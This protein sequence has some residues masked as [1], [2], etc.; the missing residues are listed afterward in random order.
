[1]I[2]LEHPLQMS[3]KLQE[4]IFLQNLA[5]ILGLCH[6]NRLWSAVW[7]MSRLN[8]SC[9]IKGQEDVAGWSPRRCC[10]THIKP[11]T[12]VLDSKG[13]PPPYA[14]LVSPN[15]TFLWGRVSST[16]YGTGESPLHLQTS[17]PTMV[18]KPRI[19][20]PICPIYLQNTFMV[21]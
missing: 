5:W 2:N 14:E 11:A 6:R 8:R 18:S 17:W 10:F 1:M 3:N 4:N 20:R 13:A 12:K 7:R 15:Q 21:I 9:L 19:P 16:T